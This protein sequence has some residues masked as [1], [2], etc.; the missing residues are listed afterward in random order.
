M[1][2]LD[3]VDEEVALLEEDEL[4]DVDEEEEDIVDVVEGEDEEPGKREA[5]TAEED[6]ASE[7]DSNAKLSSCACGKSL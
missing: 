6:L 4:L 2:E 1:E 5:T 3:A 7:I